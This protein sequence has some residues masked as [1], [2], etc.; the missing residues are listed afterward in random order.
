MMHHGPSSVF[1]CHADPR[2]GYCMYVPPARAHRPDLVVVVHGSLRMFTMMRDAFSAFARWNHCVVLCPLFPTDVM[3]D[4][5]DDGYKYL[6]EGELRYDRLLLA[7]IDEAAARHDMESERFGL[8]GYSG[9]G[10][11]AHRFF[12]LHPERLWAVS[13]GAPGS[14]T[15]LDET[16]DW[17]VGVRNVRD[18]FGV[19]IDIG[20]MRRV[21]VQMIVGRM[22]LETFEIMHE[23]GDRYWMPGAND[24]GRNRP[25]RLDALR[26]SY[27]AHG[28]GVRLDVLPE[29]AHDALRCATS[30]E[31]FLAEVLRQRRT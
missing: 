6:H 2:F 16:R 26:R 19:K 18:L 4:A 3:G 23:Q 11:F 30:A 12:T 27:E 7:I 17:W 1:A 14:V 8:F 24:A 22:D 28:I 29:V 9:G 13:I 21:P 25:E 5:N 10:H 20:A 31:D 15:Q